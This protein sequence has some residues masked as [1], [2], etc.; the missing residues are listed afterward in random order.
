MPMVQLVKRSLPILALLL[1]LGSACLHARGA[2]HLLNV[3]VGV[4][5][6]GSWL[7]PRALSA[8]SAAGTERKAVVTDTG[9]RAGAGDATSSRARVLDALDPLSWP[10]CDGVQVLIVTESMADPSWSATTVQEASGGGPRLRRVGD[11]V[12]GKR[13]AFIGY[14]PKRQLPSVWLEG[15]GGA[16]Q[17]MLFGPPTTVAVQT[18]PALEQRSDTERHVDRALVES[19]LKNPV[20][21]M[22]SVRV[23]PE[24]R[25]GEVVGLRL[26]GIRPEA[27]LGQIGLRNGDRL[28]AINGF[29][30][31]SPEKALQAYA[32]L[33]TAQRLNVRLNRGGKPLELT[34]NIN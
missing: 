4:T 7:T 24:R 14:N 28:E 19:S 22:R 9:P 32:R 6:W 10:V 23:V 3:L 8:T 29:S 13:V 31:A 21:L 27:L 15:A 17:S 16:C 11:S 1:L 12:S 25:D 18:Q 33:R 20:Q 2:Q 34:L 26:F 5:Q 30:V